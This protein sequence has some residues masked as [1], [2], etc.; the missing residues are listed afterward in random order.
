M[1]FVHVLYACH[2]CRGAWE[3]RDTGFPGA[4]FIGSWELHNMSSG[5]GISANK[6]FLATKSSP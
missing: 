6:M 3:V 1:Y 2:V 4:V 5:N